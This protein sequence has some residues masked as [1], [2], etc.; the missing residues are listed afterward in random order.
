MTLAEQIRSR[1]PAH[2]SCEVRPKSNGEMFVCISQVRSY[3]LTISDPNRPVSVEN[4]VA[5][6]LEVLG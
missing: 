6:A 2:L 3:N 4:V 5:N 1:L